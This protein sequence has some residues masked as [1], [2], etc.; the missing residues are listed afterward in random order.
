MGNAGS[1]GDWPRG[2]KLSILS[3]VEND[4]NAPSNVRVISTVV[5]SAG[6]AVA[7]NVSTTATIDARDQHDFTQEI[8]VGHPKL[9][10][11]EERNLYKLISEVQVAGQAVDRYETTFGIRSVQFDAARGFLLNGAAVKLKAPATTRTTRVLALH[12]PTPCSTTVCASCRRWA[13]TRCGPRT[14]ADPGTSGRV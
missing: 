11:L 9:W 12:C 13:A 6:A 8:A 5:D 3:E 2:A 14:S 10:S 1:I 4:G 7:R